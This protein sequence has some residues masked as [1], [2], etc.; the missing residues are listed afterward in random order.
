VAKTLLE[1]KALLEER[2]GFSLELSAM[3]D[4]DIEK[5]RGVSIRGSF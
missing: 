5:D 4:I 1:N 3:R 2:L